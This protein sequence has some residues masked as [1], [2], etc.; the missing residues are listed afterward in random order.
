VSGLFIGADIGGTN[1]KV[2]L[3]NE[4]GDLLAESQIVT[5]AESGPEQVIDRVF[6][7]AQRLLSDI[8]ASW[9]EVDGV[10]V[11][12]AG[13]IRSST[14]VLVTSPNLPNWEDVPLA[15]IL[16]SATDAEVF[17]DNDV[18]AFAYAESRVGVARGKSHGV[19]LALG[20][21]VGGGLLINGEIYR[22]HDGFGAELG[23][24]VINPSG[25]VCECGNR[26]CL[27]SLVRSRTI[28]ETARES[29]SKADR[30]AELEELA[31]GD[32]AALT[33]EALSIAASHGDELAIGVFRE[34]GRWLGIAVGGFINV[35]NPEIVV[36]GG[37]VA[38]AGELLLGPC[39]HWAGRYAFSASYACAPIVHASLGE[40]AGMV[41]AA[42]EARDRSGIPC[43]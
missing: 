19:F 32:M 1:V 6:S 26:G 15:R 3:V 38:Q 27:E 33:P 21:G 20:T 14:S 12:C 16:A 24:V 5:L 8:G 2:G 10:G 34:T 22:G 29:Y 35:F 11:G 28:V 9:R 37:G 41:G 31:G 4:E 13:L 39:R 36:I 43:G 30:T 18:N 23:H 7:D 40:N 17:L 25:P 42:L